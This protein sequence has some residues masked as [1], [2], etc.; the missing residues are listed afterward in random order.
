M[1]TWTGRL[2]A[3]VLLAGCSSEE[4]P[5]RGQLMIA[6][7]SDMSIPKDIDN[8]RAQVVRGNGTLVH[9]RTYWIEP[10][11]AG[12]TRLPATLAVVA[13]GSGDEGI[14]VRVIASRGSEARMFNKVQTAIPGSR[15]ATLRMPVQWLCD[16]SASRIADDTYESACSARNGDEYSCVAGTCQPAQVDVDDLPDFDAAAIFGGGSGPDDLLGTCFDT[17]ACFDDGENVEPNADCEIEVDVPSGGELNVALKFPFDDAEPDES[18]GICGENGCYVPLDKDERFGWRG[19]PAGTVELP[20]AVCEKL[21]SGAVEQ[22][23]VC[24]TQQTKTPE[25]PT[26]GP[27]SS[28]ASD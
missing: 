22:V 18:P 5:M 13:S 10:V 20:P 17:T 11:E 9:D 23:R 3:L 28:V 21:A 24:Y 1:L 4:E 6:L 19:D 7:S 15:L 8:I 14:E 27:W 16:G 25:F 26:C 12:D 2:C